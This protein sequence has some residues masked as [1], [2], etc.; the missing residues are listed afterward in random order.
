[1]PNPPTRPHEAVGPLLACAIADAYGA[2]FEMTSAA[3]VKKHNRMEGYIPHPKFTQRAA[4]AYTDDTQMA[5]GLAEHLL[6]ERAF[7]QLELATTWVDT[8]HR[9]QRT[10]YSGN[11]YAFLCQTK[12]GA[13]FVEG[14]RP[15]STKNGGA[16]RAFPVGFHRDPWKVR[17]LAMMQASLTHATWGGMMAAAAAALL[18][19]HRYHRLGTKADVVPFLN[20]WVPGVDWGLAVLAPG[21]APMAGSATDGGATVQRAVAVFLEGQSLADVIQ[22]AVAL[23]GDTDTVAAIAAPA[24]AV[25]QE[26][27]NALPAKII[28]DL[29]NGAFGLDYLIDLDAKLRAKFLRLDQPASVKARGKSKATKKVQQAAESG[30]VPAPDEGPCDFLFR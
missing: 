7:N 14:I 26:T 4:N 2:G 29:E 23:G 13:E 15:D 3:Y 25:C 20:K 18:F 17:D 1:M 8:F 10:G 27:R 22:M 12:T 30:T 28:A 19:H 6:N 24:A 5:V 21:D 11:F 16:M 9:D